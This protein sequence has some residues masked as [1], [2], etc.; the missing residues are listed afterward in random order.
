MLM[1]KSVQ[2][3]NHA[4]YTL[5]SE[6]AYYHF[7]IVLAIQMKTNTVSVENTQEYGQ[8]NVD[9]LGPSWSSEVDTI[10]R[11]LIPNDSCSHIQYTFIPV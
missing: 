4:L 8:Q 10:F 1:R 6:V 2:D 11:P 3:E 7:C 5:T 9:S